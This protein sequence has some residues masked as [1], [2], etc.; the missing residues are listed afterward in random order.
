MQLTTLIPAYKP[1]YLGQAFAGLQRQTMR[2]FRVIVSDDSAGGVIETMLREGRWAMQTAGLEIRVLP[3]PKNA[4]RNHERLL[5]LWGGATPY[6]HFQLDDDVV[7][8]DFYRAHLDA[9]AGGDYAA[10]ISQRWLSQTDAEPAGE[11]P[12]PDFVRASALR[13]VPVSPR[14]LYA[15]TLPGCVNWLGELSNIVFTAAA[16]ARYPRP[17]CDGLS[18]YGLLDVGAL[19]ECGGDAPLVFLRDHLSVFRQHPQQTSQAVGAGQHGHRVTV[20]AW[21]AYA[22][23][24]WRQG[25]IDALQALQALYRTVQN[26]HHFYPAGDAAIDGFL[27][28]MPPLDLAGAVSLDAL[29][30]AYTRTWLEL[31]ASHPATSAREPTGALA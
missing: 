31:L 4:R 20:L 10:S 27:A 23:H 26:C 28:L 17:P 5:D 15:S 18:Y 1:D 14:D 16:A 9:L 25:R 3:G 11:L 7:Y 13:A 19:L 12:L 8:P 22:L 29:H 21:A 24:A 30:T 6:V 2:D